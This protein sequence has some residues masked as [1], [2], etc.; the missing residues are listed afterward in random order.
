[1]FYS[2]IIFGEKIILRGLWPPNL[3][4]PNTQNFYLWSRLKDKVYKNNPAMK[5]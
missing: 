5:T 1:M 3:S 4:H 2:K